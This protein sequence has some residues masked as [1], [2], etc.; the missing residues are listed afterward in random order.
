MN[1]REFAERFQAVHGRLWLIAAGMIGDR[2]EAED[3]VQEAAIIAFRKLS[4]FRAGTSFSAWL[5]QIVRHCSANYRRKV[6]GRRTYAADPESFDQTQ[7][8]R[9]APA[10]GVRVS[11]E[12]EDAVDP[13]RLDLDDEMMAAL[14]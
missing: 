8:G 1:R 2:T 9:P 3:I 12:L 13:G 5:A 4:D 11:E 14:A 7:D 10:D 6:S